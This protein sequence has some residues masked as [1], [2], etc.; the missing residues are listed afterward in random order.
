LLHGF[1]V[2]GRRFEFLGYS[3]S[4]LRA[5]SVFAVSPFQHP[6]K[7]WITASTIRD[8]LGIFDNV[9]RFPALYAARLSQ[10]FSGTE[11]SVRLRA[12]QWEEMDDV[13]HHDRVFTDGVGTISPE[14]AKQIWHALCRQ[15]QKTSSASFTPVAFQIRFGGYKGMVAVDPLLTGTMM[16]LRPSMRKFEVHEREYMPLDIA[17]AFEHPGRMYLNR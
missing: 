3:Q 16:R 2:A 12:D 8:G 9:I 17:R 4:Q 5:H 1:K 15:R 14:L 10:A 13:I 11:A 6:E 7:G